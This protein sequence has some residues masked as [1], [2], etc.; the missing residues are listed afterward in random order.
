M[1][2]WLGFYCDDFWK[3]KRHDSWRIKGGGGGIDKE[4]D[5]VGRNREAWGHKASWPWIHFRS[6]PLLLSLLPLCFLSPPLFCSVSVVAVI[7]MAHVWF[8]F[9]RCFSLLKTLT[10]NAGVL[11]SCGSWRSSAQPAYPTLG[12]T[13]AGVRPF[14]ERTL[15][16][17]AV[18]AAG[19]RTAAP[20]IGTAPPAGYESLRNETR[21]LAK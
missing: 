21:E 10:W 5:L 16:G 11:W 12:N 18:A 1:L 13:L 19:T 7:S 4:S 2:I 3:Y 15:A 9:I 20:D 6:F 17:P 14:G 8:L